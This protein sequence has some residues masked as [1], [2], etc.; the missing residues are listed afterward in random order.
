M[1]VDDPSVNPRILDPVELEDPEKEVNLKRMSNDLLLTPFQTEKISEITQTSPSSWRTDYSAFG[2]MDLRG[3]ATISP[4][5]NHTNSNGQ[6]IVPFR[7]HENFPKKWRSHVIDSVEAISSYIQDCILFE[8]DTETKKHNDNFIVVTCGHP[9]T[10][11]PNQGCWSHL[12]MVGG[13]QRISLETPD[14]STSLDPK[15]KACM[16][17]GTIQHEFMHALG[18][19]HEHMRPDRDEYVRVIEKNI[20]PGMKGQFAKINGVDYQFMDV[21]TERKSN[22][23]FEIYTNLL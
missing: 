23:A 6:T 7:F 16:H 20:F 9:E 4:R 2:R 15:F 3:A 19:L 17:K 14:C 18:F 1:F 11:A 12:G 22:N 21:K 5:W 8:D 10:G 13:A